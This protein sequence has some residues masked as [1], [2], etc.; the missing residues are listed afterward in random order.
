MNT[1]TT[2]ADGG[3]DLTIHLTAAE[4]ASIGAVDAGR[5]GRVDRH[6]ANGA[7]RAAVRR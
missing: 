5:L 6:R 1:I 2:T 3:A 7:G 4:L